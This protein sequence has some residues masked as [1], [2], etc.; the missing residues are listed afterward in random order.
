LKEAIPEEVKMNGTVFGSL[1][2]L[3][4]DGKLDAMENVDFDP[5]VFDF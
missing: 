1:F 3:N 4:V 2:D 5:D